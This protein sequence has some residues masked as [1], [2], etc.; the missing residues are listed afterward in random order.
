[1]TAA[2]NRK[3]LI[4]TAHI[5][6][7]IRNIVN[8]EEYDL[9]ICADA[10][11]LLAAA[12]GVVPNVVIG[13]FDSIQDCDDYA[14]DKMD[15]DI[16]CITLPTAKDDT[17]TLAAVK[18]AIREGYYRIRMLGGIGA[19]LDHT[20]ANLQTLAYG[21]ECGA[22]ITMSD[23]NNSAFLL[24]DGWAEVMKKDNSYL[25]IFSW[26][27]ES[28]HVSIKGTAYD[29]DDAEFSRKFPVGVS[30]EIIDERASIAI[31]KGILLV[32]VSSKT[33]GGCALKTVV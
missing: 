6:G 5:D 19:R 7:K 26:S 9:I 31:G 28:K 16:R 18:F 32:V 24:K 22:F 17:D 21:L 23:E 27:D 10:G 2:E 11:Y 33:Q 1:M 12:E 14:C 4:I 30:N 29:V 20:I 25:S 8:P 15:S 3:A 13:D